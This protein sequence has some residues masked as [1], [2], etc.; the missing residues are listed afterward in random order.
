MSEHKKLKKAKEM[1]Q[2][3]PLFLG[4]KKIRH[5]HMLLVSWKDLRKKLIPG[6]TIEILE[7]FPEQQINI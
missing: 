4:K 5:K 6:Q 3:S 1:I 7:L 2:V